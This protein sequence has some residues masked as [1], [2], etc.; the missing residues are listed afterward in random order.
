VAQE[1][2]IDFDPTVDFNFQRFDEIP[3]IDFDPC[4]FNWCLY[5]GDFDLYL[6]EVGD[7]LIE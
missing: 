7:F 4:L 2:S 3:E 1:I 6:F 5:F